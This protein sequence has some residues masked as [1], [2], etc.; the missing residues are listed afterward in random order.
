MHAP[1]NQQT[2]GVPQVQP[3]Q[4]PQAQAQRSTVNVASVS[5]GVGRARSDSAT[6]PRMPRSRPLGPRNPSGSQGPNKVSS[7][8]PHRSR[9]GSVSS[10]YAHHLRP[11]IGLGAPPTPRKLSTASGRGRPGPRFPTVPVKLRGYTLDVARWTFTSQQLQ[12][13]ASRAIEASAQSYYV[14][15]LKLETLDTE[16]PEE[17]HRLELLTTD[18]KTRLRAAAGARRELLDALTVHASGAGTLDH[19]NLEMVVEELGDVTQLAE[20]LNDGLYTVTD[21]ITQLKRLRDVHSSSALAVSLRKL[22]T[23]FLRQAADNRLLRERVAALEA[24]RDIA[25]TQAERVA[26]EFDDLS[27]K[28]EQCAA[29]APSSANSSRRASHVSVARESS[30][31]ISKSGLRQ[32]TLGMA[33]PRTSTRSSS[34]GSAIQLPYDIP[35]VP[36]L[37]GAQELGNAIAQPSRRRPPFIQTMNLP[38]QV[39]PSRFTSV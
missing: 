7:L 26:Q 38:D 14:R 25:W 2:G 33:S 1:P 18:L 9:Q 11:G 39:T 4:H 12:E 29:P 27:A 16:L 31:R 24:E 6:D 17:L 10:L 34:V 32:P 35:P 36:P 28:L 20:E 37:P 13:I 5:E 21:Q 3:V 8:G 19:Q 30:V 15:L 23:S 22:N